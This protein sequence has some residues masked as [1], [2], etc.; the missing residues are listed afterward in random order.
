MVMCLCRWLALACADGYDEGVADDPEE[1]AEGCRLA[2]GGL[3]RKDSSIIFLSYLNRFVYGFCLI[4]NLSSSR[5]W[6]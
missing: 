6:L 1:E 3:T 5:V 4:W 2:C